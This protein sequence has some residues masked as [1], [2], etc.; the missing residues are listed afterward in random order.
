MSAGRP[1][2]SWN[3]FGDLE[4]GHGS[5]HEQIQTV[6][7]TANF[8]NLEKSAYLARIKQD[9]TV[10]QE[11]LC[12]INSSSFTYGFNNVVL[13]VSFSDHVYWIAK[14]QHIPV[15]ASE[16]LENSMDIL[17][18][19]ATM[20]T[21][22]DRTTIPVPQVFAFDVH[23]SNTVGY[24]Y[25]A[26][27]LAEV[28]FQL[29]GLTFD[30]LGRLWCG[31]SGD[32][33]PEIVPPSI[34]NTPEPSQ[35]PRTSLEWF[36]T[37]RQENNR[38]VLKLHPH[39]SEWRTACWILKTAVPHIIVE[40][41]TVPLERL[42][43]SPEIITFPGGSDEQ[44]NN[45]LTFKSLI[46]EHLQHLEQTE[47]LGNKTSSTLLLSDAF[48]SKRAEITHRCTYSLP[49]RALWDGRLVARLMYGNDVAWEQ[50]VRVYGESEI[51]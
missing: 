41:R 7:S 12:T 6:L 44:N 34:H 42:V 21:A 8:R 11:V 49:H 9:K 31:Q 29:H 19:I 27:Q 38:H 16:S 15:D 13:E 28:L 25:V 50:L 4:P 51:C 24:P 35:P 46:R 45:I 22:K 32:G 30:R 47:C 17:S 40:T 26:R 39:D 1:S 3:G 20:R 48:G 36:C 5:L 43:V 37:H 10:D 14:I 2:D 33:P 18:E 23:P